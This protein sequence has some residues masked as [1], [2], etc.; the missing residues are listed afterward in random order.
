ML[1]TCFQYQLTFIDQLSTQFNS[2][3]WRVIMIIG[4]FQ[5]TSTWPGQQNLGGNNKKCVRD[6]PPQPKKEKLYQKII[7]SQ[8]QFRQK[9]KNVKHYCIETDFRSILQ[10]YFIHISR[11]VHEIDIGLWIF[12]I[13]RNSNSTNFSRCIS[14]QGWGW[15]GVFT[16]YIFT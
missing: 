9:K 13:G 16:M 14:N 8:F 11:V 7:F 3:E 12:N 1:A 4:V 5:G 10:Y 6:P 15:V 2:T